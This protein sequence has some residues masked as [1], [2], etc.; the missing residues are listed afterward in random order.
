MMSISARKLFLLDALG[1]SL[2]AVLLGG[3]LTTFYSSFGMPVPK[4]YILAAMA[5]TLAVYS[6]WNYFVFPQNWRL[7]LRII[8]LANCF[9]CGFT[10]SLVIRNF[11]ELTTLGRAYFIGE[12]LIVLG[13]AT[14]EYRKSR[15]R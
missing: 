8:A 1:A 4:L 2:S 15:N 9:Y 7:F 12:L 13:L 10:L 3:A 14:V 6:F 11:S 5:A